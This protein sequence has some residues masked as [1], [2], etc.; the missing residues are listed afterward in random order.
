MT[1]VATLILT[2][3]D[4]AMELQRR[5]AGL[6]ASPSHR[7]ERAQATLE[8]YRESLASAIREGRDV[9]PDEMRFWQDRIDRDRATL[10]SIAE[11]ND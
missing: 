10:K 8:D 1:A 11:K 9:T 3:F 7:V 5:S 6:P 4:L 2:A